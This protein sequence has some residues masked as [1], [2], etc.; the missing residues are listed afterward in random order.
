MAVPTGNNKL[1]KTSLSSTGAK[2]F[3]DTWPPISCGLTAK[4][5]LIYPSSVEI[6]MFE[7]AIESKMG[8]NL[9][10]ELQ[11]TYRVEVKLMWSCYALFIGSLDKF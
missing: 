1:Y 11:L 5:W 10:N 7:T 3:K 8:N 4:I 9:S 6:S 2:G